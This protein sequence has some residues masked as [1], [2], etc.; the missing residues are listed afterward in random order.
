MESPNWNRFGHFIERIKEQ[1]LLFQSF[2]V[3]HMRREANLASHLL[4]KAV[5]TQVLDN[6]WLENFLHFLF[7]IVF[8][9][10]TTPF[11]LTTFNFFFNFFLTIKFYKILKKKKKKKNNDDSCP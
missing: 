5:F 2:S 9:E 7:D 1:S 4:T 10:A 3:F 6:V 8:K 11:F